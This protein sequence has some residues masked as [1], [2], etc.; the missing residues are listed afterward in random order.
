MGG[1]AQSFAVLSADVDKNENSV[2]CQRP[3]ITLSVCCETTTE[4]KGI[5][6]SP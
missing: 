3:E 1:K 5:V 4:G 6:R 2:G